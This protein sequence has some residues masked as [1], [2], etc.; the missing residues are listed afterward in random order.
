MDLPI[1]TQ[2]M[3][4]LITLSNAVHAPVVNLWV[5]ACFALKK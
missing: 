4:M 2:L 3:A 5:T 1:A